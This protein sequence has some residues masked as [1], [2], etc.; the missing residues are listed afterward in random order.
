MIVPQL[1]S[2]QSNLVNVVKDFRGKYESFDEA[3]GT[4]TA[5][6]GDDSI[7]VYEPFRISGTIDPV[8]MILGRNT[9]LFYRES[10]RR[11][12]GSLGSAPIVSGN[13]YV[14]GRREPADSKLLVWSPAEEVEIEQYDSRVRI[15]PSRIHAA[16]F[17]LEGGEVL[18]AD[19]GSSS[20]SILAGETAKPEPFIIL[21][22]TPKVNVHKVTIEAKYAR[23]KRT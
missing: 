20:G 8:C 4:Y 3:F 1:T 17:A 15:I 12:V 7:T 13:V 5:Q 16:V 10:R 21:Y 22:A 6:Y 2:L 11:L 18:F 14:L 19:L 9:V 23:S